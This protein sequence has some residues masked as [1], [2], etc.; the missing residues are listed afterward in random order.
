MS[1]NTE[2]TAYIEEENVAQ[3]HAKKKKPVNKDSVNDQI[4]QKKEISCWKFLTDQCSTF[5]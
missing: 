5:R 3:T 2:G 4:Y 1:T